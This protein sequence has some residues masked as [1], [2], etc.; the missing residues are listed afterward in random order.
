VCGRAGFAKRARLP[1]RQDRVAGRVAAHQWL[2]GSVPAG[3]GVDLPLKALWRRFGVPSAILALFLGHYAESNLGFECGALAARRA[4]YQFV[5]APRRKRTEL[6][7]GLRFGQLFFQKCLARVASGAGR[8]CTWLRPPQTP[9][10]E[11]GSS[12]PARRSRS[13]QVAEQR[14]CWTPRALRPP[15]TALPC[16]SEARVRL[17]DS[18]PCER[19]RPTDASSCSRGEPRT[20]AIPEEGCVEGVPGS[21][22]AI[23]VLSERPCFVWGTCD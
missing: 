16:A 13:G 10:G 7:Q 3:G 9:T 20:F 21:F 12:L 8:R 19:S 4:K 5:L 1:R 17:N 18:A 11:S 6:E 15:R 14:I 22:C 2:R 23:W